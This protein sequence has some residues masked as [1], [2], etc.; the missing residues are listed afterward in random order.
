M[1]L[2]ATVGQGLGPTGRAGRAGVGTALLFEFHIHLHMQKNLAR[3][4]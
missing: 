4:V 2:A 3:A 1:Q